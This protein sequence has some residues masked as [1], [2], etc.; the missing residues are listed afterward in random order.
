MENELLPLAVPKKPSVPDGGKEGDSGRT[1]YVRPDPDER[2][3][4]GTGLERVGATSGY[5]YIR[6]NPGKA[7]PTPPKREPEDLLRRDDGIDY[8]RKGL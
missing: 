7:R 1:V 8:L 5:N 4:D 2:P 3:A 6:W